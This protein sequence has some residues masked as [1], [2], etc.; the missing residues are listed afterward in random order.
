MTAQAQPSHRENFHLSSVHIRFCADNSGALSGQERCC[1]SAM[2]ILYCQG[3]G[4]REGKKKGSRKEGST[5]TSM[6]EKAFFPCL[7]AAMR[8]SLYSLCQ[9][10]FRRL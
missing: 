3:K 10:R 4:K 8:P 9:T 1:C 5:S 2:S 7:T 6:R